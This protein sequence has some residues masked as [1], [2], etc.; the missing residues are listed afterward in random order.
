LLIILV[1]R[2]ILVDGFQ[3]AL[4]FPLTGLSSFDLGSLGS[5]PCFLLLSLFLSSLSSAFLFF[6]LDLAGF[7]L[8][9]K[10]L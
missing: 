1:G 9:F 10:C 5:Q 4:Q 7:D 3:L 8:L 6:F 2:I